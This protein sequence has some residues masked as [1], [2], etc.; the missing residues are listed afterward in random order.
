MRN[1]GSDLQLLKKGLRNEHALKLAPA[2][3][4]V[5]SVSNCKVAAINARLYG[6]EISSAQASR[7]VVELDEQFCHLAVTAIG[8]DALFLTGRPPWPTGLRRMSRR[9]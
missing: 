9:N 3:M 5:Q 4:F 6:T 7:N 1:G 2:E 8:P